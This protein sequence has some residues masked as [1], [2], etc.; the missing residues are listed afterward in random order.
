[1]YSKEYDT[2]AAYSQ[3]KNKLKEIEKKTTS[4]IITKVEDLG[5]KSNTGASNRLLNTWYGFGHADT[6]TMNNIQRALLA[7]NAVYTSTFTKESDIAELANQAYG[8]VE[9]M[10]RELYIMAPSLCPE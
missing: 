9:S 8:A 6:Q 5:S 1:M 2:I 10:K 4:N 7:L 3:A